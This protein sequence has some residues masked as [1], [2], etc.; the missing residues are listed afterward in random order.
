MSEKNNKFSPP[1]CP[2]PFVMK[3]LVL[4]LVASG[5]NFS[6]VLMETAS[7]I[8]G[9]VMERKTVRTAVMRRAAMVP[10]DCV[11]TKPS[12][13]AGVQVSPVYILEA[14]SSGSGTIYSSSLKS[15]LSLW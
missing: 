3:K 4:L 7:L 12:F 14:E 6:A 9:A 5:M 8:C 15:I 2:S 11:T 1:F 13:P 10:F